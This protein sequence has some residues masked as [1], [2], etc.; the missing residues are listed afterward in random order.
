MADHKTTVILAGSAAGLVRTMTEAS[1]AAEAS[2][3]SMKRSFAGVDVDSLRQRILN[4]GPAFGVVES[5]ATHAASVVGNAMKTMAIASVGLGSLGV[6]AGAGFGLVAVAAVA[7]P[8]VKNI[9]AAL[10]AQSKAQ[11][12]TAASAKALTAAMGKLSSPEKSM[13][14]QVDKLKA[15]Y[16]GWSKSLQPGLM[17]TFSAG[18]TIANNVLKSTP[19]LVQSVEGVFSSLTSRLATLSAGAGFKAFIAQ[20][21]AMMPALESAI[22]KIGGL[23][24]TVAN[25]GASLAGPALSIIGTLSGSLSSLLTSAGPGLKAFIS[26]LSDFASNALPAVASALGPVVDALGDALG[27]VLTQL[28]PIL[29]QLAPMIGQLLVGAV[30]ALA[31]VLDVVVSAIKQLLPAITPLIGPVVK[32]AQTFGSQLAAMIA[33]ILPVIVPLIVDLARMA[34]PILSVVNAMMKNKAAADAMILGLVALVSPMTAI[35]A[36]AALVAANWKHIWHDITAWASD[37][38]DAIKKAFDDALDFIKDHARLIEAALALMLGPLGL[39]MAATL[40]LATHWKQDWTAITGALSTAWSAIRGTF[41]TVV[42]FIGGM[43]DRIASAASGMWDGIKDA[44]RDAIDFI[45]RGWDALHFKMPSIN[46]HIPGIGKIGGFDVGMPH[47]PLLAS[48]GIITAP[49]L[50]VL[51][52]AGPEAVVP[53]NQMQT[54]GGPNTGMQVHLHFDGPFVGGTAA[55]AQRFGQW[56]YRAIVPVVQQQARRT[57][58]TGL[59]GVGY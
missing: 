32:L 43:P 27:P 40:E 37:A 53:L 1:A 5:A 45:I 4:V 29:A 10:Q 11:D 49:M 19:S 16:L 8:A 25:V 28:G 20:V 17:P 9:A 3:Q 12:G 18:L 59:A 50:A 51:G 54:G 13:V 36:V 26:G 57:G 48:G 34:A 58:V 52:E 14:T 35:I 23:I 38:W 6:A 56:V 22:G 39:I 21:Q 41:D 30:S 46:T 15:S 47:I 33:R 42:S 24:G 44:F 7:A 55:D 31:P 2:A